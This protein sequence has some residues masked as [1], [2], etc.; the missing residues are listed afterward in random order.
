MAHLQFFTHTL[1]FFPAGIPGK[2]AR[3]T[4]LPRYSWTGR[5]PKAR[6]VAIRVPPSSSRSWGWA[7][8]S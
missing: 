8:A 2:A 4:A 7:G 6:A 5:M 1:S 3:K